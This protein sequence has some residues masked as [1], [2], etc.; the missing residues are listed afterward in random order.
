MITRDSL[1]SVEFAMAVAHDWGMGAQRPIYRRFSRSGISGRVRRLF[2]G[3]GKTGTLAFETGAT[4]GWDQNGLT[5]VLATER[6]DQNPGRVAWRHRGFNLQRVN[7][8]D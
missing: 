7:V 8:A 3:H 6:G 1:L 4:L 5:E 2:L